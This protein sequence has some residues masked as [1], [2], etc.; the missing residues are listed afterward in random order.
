M[1]FHYCCENPCSCGQVKT[2][3]NITVRLPQQTLLSVGILKA[4]RMP[5]SW[6]CL[7][8]QLVQNQ[9]AP[10]PQAISTEQL[11]PFTALTTVW[12][13]ALATTTYQGSVNAQLDNQFKM[14]LWSQL[15]KTTR[16]MT[17]TMLAQKKGDLARILEELQP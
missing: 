15:L 3:E 11:I 6:A 17:S 16:A 2:L 10:C 12:A 9:V 14:L 4:L 5:P 13:H 8:F 1:P 7:A